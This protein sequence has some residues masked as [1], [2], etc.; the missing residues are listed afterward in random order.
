MADKMRA[1]V[2]TKAA[3]GLEMQLVDIPSIGPRDVLVRVRAASICG[4]DLHIWN[5]DAWSQGRIKPPVITGHE[6]G[7]EVV[8]VGEQVTTVV[9]GD[10]V[11][12]ECHIVCGTCYQCRTGQSHICQ[13]VSRPRMPG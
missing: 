6:F 4:T 7:G 5:W 2:K 12:A 10:F 11:S 8:E 13:N 3:P 1:M 9:P